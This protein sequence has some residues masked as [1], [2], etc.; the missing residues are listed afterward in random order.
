MLAVRLQNGAQ[1]RLNVL[2]HLASW[3]TTLGPCKDAIYANGD[4]ARSVVSTLS[5]SAIN[6]IPV[7]GPLAPE[8]K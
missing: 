2:F 4:I 1:N 7:A 8:A 6:Q 3:L 5:T